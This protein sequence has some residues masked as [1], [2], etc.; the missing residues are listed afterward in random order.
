MADESRQGKE[1][2]EMTSDKA[3]PIRV[4]VVDDSKIIRERVA[5][6][7]AE[8]EDVEVVAEAADA[9][10]GVEKVQQHGP[11]VVVLDIRMP[12]GSGLGVLEK[13]KSW[14]TSLVAIVLTNY[15]YSSY[16]S[17]CMELGADFFFDKS[18]EFEKVGDVVRD[19]LR[20]RPKTT[21]SSD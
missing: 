13:I 16:R 7:L 19:L 3:R 17:R 4:V 20:K 12:G 11:D 21:P 10:G 5:A 14:K 6:M 8:I 1:G 18:K 2:T 9:W 15:S